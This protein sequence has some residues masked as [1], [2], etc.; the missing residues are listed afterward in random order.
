MTNM[1]TNMMKT[2]DLVTM[3]ATAV[4]VWGEHEM[5]RHPD[6]DETLEP[7]GLAMLTEVGLMHESCFEDLTFGSP[8]VGTLTR[9]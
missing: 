4:Q 9:P 6:C 5:C 1:M 7:C 2:L 8:S 3:D